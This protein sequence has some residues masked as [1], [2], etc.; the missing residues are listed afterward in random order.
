MIEHEVFVFWTVHQLKAFWNAADSLQTAPSG[1]IQPFLAVSIP[2]E[3][4]FFRSN[5]VF[6]D[7]LQDR[8]ILLDAFVDQFVHL[9]L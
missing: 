5:D 3:T 4:D 2:F 9:F 6:A 8:F 7:Y 1:F